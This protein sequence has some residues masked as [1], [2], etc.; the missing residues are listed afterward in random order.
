MS[1]PEQ[2]Q[3][4]EQEQEPVIV[5]VNFVRAL[6]GLEEKLNEYYPKNSR[7]IDEFL[8]EY[9]KEL[10]EGFLRSMFSHAYI[11]DSKKELS[12]IYEQFESP[13]EVRT[14]KEEEE[15][16]LTSSRVYMGTKEQDTVDI[17]LPKQFADIE[18]ELMDVLAKF[19]RKNAYIFVNQAKSLWNKKK[20]PFFSM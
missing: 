10:L 19:V 4:Q 8:R 3:E 1:I 5:T 2:E 18:F 11:E 12:D 17:V 14:D 9:A 6:R 7:K 20:N 16:A 15:Y 13:F